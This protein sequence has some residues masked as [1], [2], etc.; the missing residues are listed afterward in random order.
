LISVALAAPSFA[1]KKA[2]NDEQMDQATAKGQSTVSKGQGHQTIN[3]KAKA[4]VELKDQAQQNATAG[5]I[6][7]VAGENNVAATVNAAVS[8]GGATDSIDQRNDIDQNKAA[9]IDQSQLDLA[10]AL[11]TTSSSEEYSRTK[12]DWKLDTKSKLETK[13]KTETKSSGKEGSES[14]SFTE[15]FP[16]TT[17]AIDLAGAVGATADA[18]A[19]AESKTLST[20]TASSTVE[21]QKDFDGEKTSTVHIDGEFP[22]STPVGVGSDLNSGDGDIWQISADVDKTELILDAELELTIVK[23]DGDAAIA[24]ADAEGHEQAWAVSISKSETVID[25][26]L[27]TATSGSSSFEGSESKTKTEREISGKSE[28]S[29]EESRKVCTE[30]RNSSS[31]TYTETSS[32]KSKLEIVV[33]DHVKL[34]DGDQ[35]ITDE[36]EYQVNLLDDAQ[37]SATALNI[38]NVAGR[39]NV[40][41]AWNLASSSGG[42]IAVSPFIAGAEATV[43]GSITQVNVVKQVN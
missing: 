3:D 21:V 9:Y 17:I 27:P 6:I 25:I 32:D 2:L 24:Q 37:G 8:S 38:I 19:N 26:D 43:P 18:K 5:N 1:A 11:L 40:A 30:T 23:A 14:S 20:A 41:A 16:P 39:N 34:G 31:D 7:N 28:D 35:N 42:T 10:S 13:D 15:V 12:D 29:R 33:A 36:T 4:H 22:N